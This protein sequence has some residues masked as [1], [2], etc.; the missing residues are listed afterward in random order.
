MSKSAKFATILLGAMA[1]GL[2][3]LSAGYFMMPV[4]I[5]RAAEFITPQGLN[6]PVQEQE[7]TEKVRGFASELVGKHLLDVQV[8]IRYVRTDPK[9]DRRVKL[10]GFTGYIAPSGSKDTQVVPGH[11]R[12]RQ[13][14][15]MVSNELDS[16][17]K[18]VE[19]E[20]LAMGKFDPTQGDLVRV[21]SLKP[22]AK[23]ENG[24]EK[25]GKRNGNEKE[26]KKARHKDEMWRDAE[27]VRAESP[28]ESRRGAVRSERGQPTLADDLAE[29]ESTTFL[30]R[31]RKSY[32]KGDY[33]NALGQILQSIDQKP[34]NPQAFSML[35]SLY[36]AMGWKSLAVKYWEKSLELDPDNRELTDLVVRIRR[37]QNL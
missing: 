31:A 26:D 17:P 16:N 7:L 18:S 3:L 24:A 35:G 4:G 27:A 29:V 14:L 34:D 21:I 22:P 28:N 10:P 36:Y 32:F 30:V 6:I 13:V 12:L 2:V 33:D 11:A 1:H 23:K 19:E 25:S 20:I 15:V 37:E 8:Q 5:A 9:G